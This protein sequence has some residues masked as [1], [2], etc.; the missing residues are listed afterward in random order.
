MLAIHNKMTMAIVMTVTHLKELSFVHDDDEHR[1]LLGPSVL[2][3][4]YTALVG[5]REG[6]HE[7]YLRSRPVKVRVRTVP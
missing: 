6:S 1:S 7:L 4:L 3:R 5:S 2:L